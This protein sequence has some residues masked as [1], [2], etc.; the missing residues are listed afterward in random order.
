MPGTGEQGPLQ[1]AANGAPVSPSSLRA[2]LRRISDLLAVTPLPGDRE[3]LRS[4]AAQGMLLRAMAHATRDLEHAAGTTSRDAGCSLRAARSVL[5][6]LEG[7]GFI[8]ITRCARRHQP[9]LWRIAS[10]SEMHGL[11]P[12]RRTRGSRIGGE[13][14]RKMVGRCDPPS[15]RFAGRVAASLPS[16]SGDGLPATTIATRCS[17]SPTTVRK[18]LRHLRGLSIVGCTRELVTYKREFSAEQLELFAFAPCMRSRGLTST[19]EERWHL[20]DK[21]EWR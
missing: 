12:I 7:I 6:D 1:R 11:L 20:R 15:L 2:E 21:R 16:L 9:H 8:K 19:W 10:L 5:K 13:L 18:V 14:A 4:A 17:L 3:G